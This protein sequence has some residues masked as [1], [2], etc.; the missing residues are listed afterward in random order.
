[1]DAGRWLAQER[2]SLAVL[3]EGPVMSREVAIPI[4]PLAERI[5]QAQLVVLFRFREHL[6]KKRSGLQT[7]AD[8]PQVAGVAGG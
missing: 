8:S 5:S 6:P 1:M 3:E 2:G 4:F 7:E